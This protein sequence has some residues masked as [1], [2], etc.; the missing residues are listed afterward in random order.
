[1]KLEMD[2]YVGRTARLLAQE[3]DN[4]RLRDI[5]LPGLHRSRESH[6]KLRVSF[7]HFILLLYRNVAS[8]NKAKIIN[9]PEKHNVSLRL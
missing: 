9:L 1:M 2:G 7:I 3:M 5:E 4:R 8:Q 6:S